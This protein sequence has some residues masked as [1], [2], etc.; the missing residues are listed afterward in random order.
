M[1]KKV[2]KLHHANMQYKILM[3]KKLLKLFMKMNFKKINQ[4]DFRVKK[5][6]KV[7]GEKLYVKR[8]GCNSFQNC[9]V[10][11]QNQTVMVKTK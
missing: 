7:K 4:T 11:I 2:K 5:V 8:K 1:I 3:M 10:I 9:M 6:I